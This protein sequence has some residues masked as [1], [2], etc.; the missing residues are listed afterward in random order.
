MS[1]IRLQR[2]PE[3]DQVLEFFRSK[4]QLL[5]E[6]EIIKMVLSERFAQ[7]TNTDKLNDT[8]IKKMYQKL[9]RDGKKLG[10]DYLK[11][12]GIKRKDMTE[13]DFYQLLKSDNE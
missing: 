7:E 2:T 12:K 3:F 6:P 9:K 10:N 4:Y 1:Q 11:Q 8:D 13:E 5:S